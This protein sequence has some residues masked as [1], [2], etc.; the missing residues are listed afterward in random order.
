L[1]RSD[2][3]AG[4]KAKEGEWVERVTAG[5]S[6]GAELTVE[7][8]YKGAGFKGDPSGKSGVDGAWGAA[9]GQ[10]FAEFCFGAACC[11]VELDALSG[12][13]TVLAADIVY[14]C[15]KSA[16]PALDVGQIEGAFVMGLGESEF[17]TQSSILCFQVR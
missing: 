8:H 10:L 1:K 6:W 12:E 3:E 16:N 17:Y 11:V 4:E 5:V 9:A 7:A 15:G 13:V 2:G 14:D